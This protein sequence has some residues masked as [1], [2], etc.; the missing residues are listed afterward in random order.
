MGQKNR[1]RELWDKQVS[2]SN[3]SLLVISFVN[4]SWGGFKAIFWIFLDFKKD[5]DTIST[6]IKARVVD[7]LYQQ[8]RCRLKMRVH[9]NH[10]SEKRCPL[11]HIPFSLWIDQL[12]EFIQEPL[13]EHEEKSVVGHFIIAFE[14]RR[15]CAFDIF[16]A[17]T[18]NAFRHRHSFCEHSG[19]ATSW[20]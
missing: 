3:T 11:S 6:C 1:T 2:N 10:G 5:S 8:G 13:A 7:Q 4:E 18:A 9:K 19:L 17:E 14:F 20:W 15:H 16:S 12:E